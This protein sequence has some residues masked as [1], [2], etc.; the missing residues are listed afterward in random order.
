MDTKQRSNN[1]RDH[2]RTLALWI[3]IHITHWTL[4][5]TNL[6]ACF[7]IIIYQPWYIAI[8]ICTLLNNPILGGKFCMLNDLENRLRSKLG[9]TLIKKDFTETTINDIK[10][11]I[12]NYAK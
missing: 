11:L 1:N 10:R 6:T 3:L 5:L 2:N 4:L 7:F 9:W 8:P 12:K